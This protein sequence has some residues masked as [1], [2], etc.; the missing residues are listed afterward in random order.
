[1]NTTDRPSVSI[2]P[3]SDRADNWQRVFRRLNNIPVTAYLPALANLPHRPGV[4]I[5]E[6]DLAAITHDERTRLIEHIV[7]QFNLAAD[8]VARDL[9]AHGC[10]LLADDIIGPAIPMRLLL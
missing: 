2:R 1:M 6:L 5:Y 9:D 8:D 7:D 4:L 3:D 10:P